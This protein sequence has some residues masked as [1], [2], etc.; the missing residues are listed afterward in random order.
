MIPISLVQ[1]PDTSMYMEALPGRN[2]V[3]VRRFEGQ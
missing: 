2:I 3:H 1:D